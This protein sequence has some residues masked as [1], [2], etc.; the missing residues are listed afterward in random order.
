MSHLSHKLCSKHVKTA[1]HCS[2]RA[3]LTTSIILDPVNAKQRFKGDECRCLSV[4]ISLCFY[5]LDNLSFSILWKLYIYKR[6]KYV[7]ADT[8]A[9]GIG[10]F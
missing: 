10:L 9:H 7:Q 5:L 8:H 4:N 3:S 6:N 1:L 2:V